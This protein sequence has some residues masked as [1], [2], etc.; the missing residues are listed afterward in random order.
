MK[1]FK[2]FGSL[3]ALK[4]IIIFAV[5]LITSITVYDTYDTLKYTSKYGKFVKVGKLNIPRAGHTATLLND[6]RVLIAGGSGI[7]TID[8]EKYDREILQA[9]V[10]DPKTKQFYLSDSFTEKKRG[11]SATLLPNGNVLICGEG[12]N[13]VEIYDSKVHK[14]QYVGKMKVTRDNHAAILMNTG[15]VFVTGG[16]KVTSTEFY[17]YELNKFS[18]GPNLSFNRR[19]TKSILMGNQVVVLGYGE[20]IELFDKKFNVTVGVTC[21]Y[22]NSSIV[23]TSKGIYMIGGTLDDPT[24]HINYLNEKGALSLVGA[25]NTERTAPVTMILSNNIFL[26]TGGLKNKHWYT[27]NLNTAEVYK[28]N[29]NKS[30]LIPMRKK[31]ARH[32]LTKLK[33]GNI[34][35][36]GGDTNSSSSFGGYISSNELFIYQKETSK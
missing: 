35:M 31:R 25:L 33:N 19:N 4:K 3:P 1:I 17:D 5:I 27:E 26:I 9:E 21:N 2:T 7:V 22:F 24:N 13:S 8:G 34:L 36:V 16:W 29:Q 10:Y 23:S 14:F 12:Y 28:I 32:T 20:K 30:Y 15:D 6:G 18:S 11:H